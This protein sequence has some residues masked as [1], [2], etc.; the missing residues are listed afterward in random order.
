MWNLVVIIFYTILR[1]NI[2]LYILNIV[3]LLYQKT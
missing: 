1:K 2:L 3:T